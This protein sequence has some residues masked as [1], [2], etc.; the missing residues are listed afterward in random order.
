MLNTKCILAEPDIS[1][2]FRISVMN[3]HTLED[4]KTPDSRIKPSRYG[5]HWGILAPSSKLVGEYY[6][7]QRPWEWYEPRYL[8]EIRGA[9]KYGWV[10]LLV[11]IAMR[12]EVTVMCIEDTPEH[13]HRRLLAEECKRLRAD[14][15][16]IIR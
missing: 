3:R 8:A 1:D 6:R 13:C 10:Q 5:A 9:E 15:E 14:L 12:H 7:E 11:E 16:V 2:G 4:G